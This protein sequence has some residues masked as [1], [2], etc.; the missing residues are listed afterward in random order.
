MI[1][2]L[3]LGQ[4]CEV[5]GDFYGHTPA[6]ALV[7][8]ADTAFVAEMP[9]SQQAI[10]QQIIAAEVAHFDESG[11]RVAGRLNWLRATSTA[12]LTYYVIH[13]KQGQDDIRAIGIQPTFIGELSM[14]I[15]SPT[16][17]STIPP[18]PFATRTTCASSR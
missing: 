2:L 12:G 17:P 1:Q 18:T 6:Q 8:G 15:G 13:P 11:L 3:P 9:T 16:S 4:T 7:L 5:S 10:K 14:I